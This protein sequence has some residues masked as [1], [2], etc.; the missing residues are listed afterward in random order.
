M[1][2]SK[3]A[4]SFAVFQDTA[5][6]TMTTPVVFGSTALAISTPTTAAVPT[7]VLTNAKFNAL[8]RRAEI[9]ALD[10][11]EM[12]DLEDDN[13]TD[14]EMLDLCGTSTTGIASGD[15]ATAT[16]PTA[17]TLMTEAPVPH[18]EMTIF[19]TTEQTADLTKRSTQEEDDYHSAS[20]WEHV[21][22]LLGSW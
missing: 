2:L 12:T 14:V 1:K 15:V 20:L 7:L 4:T 18:I 10:V 17:T 8:A 13:L 5:G 19:N 6:T 11:D 22:W 9:A 21:K 16:A 3:I